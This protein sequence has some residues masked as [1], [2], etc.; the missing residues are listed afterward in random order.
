MADEPV[1]LGFKTIEEVNAFLQAKFQQ[2]MLNMLQDITPIRYD[3]GIKQLEA[4]AMKVWDSMPEADKEALVNEAWR[5]A[6]DN[7]ERIA[8]IISINL[9]VK[10]TDE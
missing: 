6:F 7:G 9:D 10:N 3:D 1:P 2:D 8:K 5:F 4:A